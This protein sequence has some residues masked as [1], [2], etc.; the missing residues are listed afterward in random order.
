MGKI[1]LSCIALAF[2]VIARRVWEL[3][4]EFDAQLEELEHLTAETRQLNERQLAML[5]LAEKKAGGR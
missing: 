1:I 4:N 2:V 5:D 3:C